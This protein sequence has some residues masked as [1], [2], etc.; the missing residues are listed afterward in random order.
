MPGPLVTAI[1]PAN[2]AHMGKATPTVPNPRVTVNSQPTVLISSPYVVAA[3]P[4]AT[5]AGPLPCVT[6][7]FTTAATRVQSGG[8]PLLLADSQAVTVP[9][10]VPVLFIPDQTRVIAQ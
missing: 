5:G 8:Q 4:F 6:A 1:T 3:C 7:Q 10:G 2:C 9:N